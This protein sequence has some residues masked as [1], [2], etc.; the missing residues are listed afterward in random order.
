MAM[1]ATA[2]RNIFFTALAKKNKESCNQPRDTEA[3]NVTNLWDREYRQF[4][5]VGLRRLNG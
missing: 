4:T 3:D 1:A 5:A 2:T